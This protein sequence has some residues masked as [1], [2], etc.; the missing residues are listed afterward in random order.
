M[1]TLAQLDALYMLRIAEKRMMNTPPYISAQEAQ[2]SDINAA[3]R[4]MGCTAASP[5]WKTVR[6][7]LNIHRVRLLVAVRDPFDVR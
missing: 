2:M 6:M 3:D 4:M 7:A 1:L 5:I